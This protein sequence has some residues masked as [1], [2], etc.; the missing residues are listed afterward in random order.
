MN[1]P[2]QIYLQVGEG[3]E[4]EDFRE[5]DLECVTWSKEPTGAGDIGPY[6]LSPV[7]NPSELDPDIDP[8]LP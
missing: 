3:N 7:L 5:C 1:H 2:K 8:T 4:K 6:V